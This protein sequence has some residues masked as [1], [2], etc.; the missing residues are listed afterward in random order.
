MPALL[1][2]GC[3]LVASFLVQPEPKK[4]AV[5]VTPNRNQRMTEEERMAYVAEYIQ[6]T[7]LTVGA[8]VEPD[9][10]EAVP[11]LQRVEGF[12]SN[13][14][15]RWID[16]VILVFYAKDAAGNVMAVEQNDVIPKG[17]LEPGQKRPFSF[18]VR[19]RS[20]SSGAFDFELR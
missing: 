2:V 11:G 4:E 5:P 12:V 8:D 17:R 16:E 14:G 1:L 20:S 10:R 3:A 7:E 9:G 15:S 19:E 18:R 13:Q 6:V